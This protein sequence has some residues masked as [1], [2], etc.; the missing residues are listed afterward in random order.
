MFSFDSAALVPLGIFAAELCVVTISTLRTIFIARG[1]RLLAP[2]LGF[3]EIL[4]W[5]FAISQIMRNLSDAWCFTAFAL[6]FTAGN[7]LGM[8]I[9]RWL[10]LGMVIIR[11]FTSRDAGNLMTELRAHNFGYTCINGEGATGPVRIVMTVVRRR[12]LDDVLRLIETSQP[13][14]FYA[15]DELQ[16]ASQGIFPLTQPGDGLVPLALRWFARLP[17]G[18]EPSADRRLAS[19]LMMAGSAPLSGDKTR[20]EPPL[21]AERSRRKIGI[22]ASESRR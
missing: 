22:S 9:E 2:M 1:R 4:I 6:G 15:I 3:F 16:E 11:I 8:Y 14:A 13:H 17:F 21:A 19:E 5:L 12:Q 7:L 18:K 20:Q 10:A